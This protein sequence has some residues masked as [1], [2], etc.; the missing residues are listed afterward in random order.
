MQTDINR[1]IYIYVKL[2][3][4]NWSTR[5]GGT[6][7]RE[8]MRGAMMMSPWSGKERWVLFLWLLLK[9]KTRRGGFR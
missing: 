7:G 2:V 1:E 4:E 9:S 5:F 6:K 3:K 8:F